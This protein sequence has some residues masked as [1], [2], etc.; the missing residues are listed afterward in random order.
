MKTS[1]EGISQDK[2]SKG[3]I[4]ITQYEEFSMKES[5]TN[6]EIHV[7][8]TAITKK[9]HCLGEVFPP[10]KQVRKIL[11]VLPESWKVRSILSQRLKFSKLL[12]WMN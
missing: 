2:E 1:H 11:D 5:K 10:G 4:L 9:L 12:K 3:D 7:R 6:Q 8:F